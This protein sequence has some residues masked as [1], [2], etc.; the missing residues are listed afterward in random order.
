MYVRRD[1]VTIATLKHTCLCIRVE[2]HTNVIYVKSY[3]LIVAVFRDTGLNMMMESHLYVIVTS[4]LL[5]IAV[6]HMHHMLDSQLSTELDSNT[7]SV[8]AQMLAPASENLHKCGVC[9]KK[10]S[11]H[12]HLKTHMLIHTGTGGRHTNVIYVKRCFIYSV[13]QS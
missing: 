10:F 1:F 3:L 13:W 7:L 6:L 11:H 5:N 4:H 2:D 9:Q 12:S 8:I